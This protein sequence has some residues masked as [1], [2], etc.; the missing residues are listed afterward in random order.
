MAATAPR[1]AADKLAE[2][3]CRHWNASTPP[4]ETP[5]QC[6]MKSERQLLRT[7]A[8]CASV[9]CAMASCAYKFSASAATTAFRKCVQLLDIAPPDGSL[10][11]EATRI[12]FDGEAGARWRCSNTVWR[13]PV[14]L[15]AIATFC[16]SETSATREVNRDGCAAAGLLDVNYARKPHDA[17]AQALCREEAFVRVGL[18]ARHG[19][20]ADLVLSC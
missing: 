16:G 5:M 8:F 18:C 4:G 17:E 11:P 7:A 6:A 10:L 2:W 13:L 1:H 15:A 3:L 12:P 19:T 14:M 20:P 9:G